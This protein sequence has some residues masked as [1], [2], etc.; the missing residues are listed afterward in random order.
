MRVER[1]D[2]MRHLCKSRQE[3]KAAY[4]HRA[5]VPEA[6]GQRSQTR[7]Q[8]LGQELNAGI[9]GGPSQLG[10]FHDPVI[11]KIPHLC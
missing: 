10:V 6:F 7:G 9:H 1:S 11:P 3:E 2:S 8:S 5:A 4:V